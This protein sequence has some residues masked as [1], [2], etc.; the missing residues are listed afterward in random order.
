MYQIT[1]TQFF[2]PLSVLY[3]DSGLEVTPARKP[4]KEPWPCGG[5]M[6]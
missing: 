3:H 5:A 4:P 2:Y 6:I 1:P